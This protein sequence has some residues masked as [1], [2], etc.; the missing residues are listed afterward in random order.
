MRG[1]RTGGVEKK[2]EATGLLDCSR[3]GACRTERNG[4]M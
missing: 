1:E 4:S 3:L 2:M